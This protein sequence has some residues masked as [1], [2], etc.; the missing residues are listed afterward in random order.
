[1]ETQNIER[2]DHMQEDVRDNI[3][4][5]SKILKTSSRPT[6]GEYLIAAHG[7]VMSTVCGPGKIWIRMPAFPYES[8]E[9]FGKSLN[10]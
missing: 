9:T 7:V 6:M 10:I 2:K 3:L 4:H 1:M 8:S 5:Y